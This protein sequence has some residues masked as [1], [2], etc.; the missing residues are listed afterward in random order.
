MS[1]AVG[2]E[3]ASRPAS[4]ATRRP[5][6]SSLEAID[7]AGYT[8]GEQIAIGLD[9]AASEFYKGRKY[10]LEG[11]GSA[12]PNGPTCWPPGSTV[13]DH[14]HRGRHARRRL[15]RL[16]NPQRPPGQKVQLVGDDLFVTNTKILERGI[17]KASPIP[18]SSRSTRSARSPRPSP[19]SRWPSAP[20]GRTSSSHRS[21]ETEDST[22]ADIAVGHQRRPDQD[23]LDEPQRPHRKVQPAA[24]A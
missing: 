9:C 3:A 6:S 16:E 4:P 15:G 22:I 12:P 11:E 20:A 10:H 23:R 8:A 7:K 17:R 5:S 18:S 13:P 24:A 1:T 21:G 19:P 14:Q 2:D